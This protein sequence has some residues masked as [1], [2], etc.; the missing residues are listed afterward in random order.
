MNRILLVEDDED[1]CEMMHNILQNDGYEIEIANNGAQALALDFV[2]PADLVITDVFM[3][4]I[5]GLETIV[6]MR[7]QNPDLHFIAI[8]G[9][10]KETLSLA[11]KMGAHA[12]LEKPFSCD[13]LL[14]AVSKLIGCS[15]RFPR[16]SLV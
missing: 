11:R 9:G 2:E 8:S 16:P 6:E 5:N 4:K 13:G 7:K 15:R 14:R 3:P 10:G 12:T 1:L